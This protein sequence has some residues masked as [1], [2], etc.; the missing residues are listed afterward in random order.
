MSMDGG[1]ESTTVTPRSGFVSEFYPFTLY[2]AGQSKSNWFYLDSASKVSALWRV[3]P[4]GDANTSAEF[5]LKLRNQ[6]TGLV[7]YTTMKCDTSAKEYYIGFDESTE[8]PAGNWQATVS[9]T[10][11][12]SG[13]YNCGIQFYAH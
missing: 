5:T 3:Q 4:V 11:A 12:F 10:G 2:Y 8:I 9:G 6:E 7:V 13:T 1:A